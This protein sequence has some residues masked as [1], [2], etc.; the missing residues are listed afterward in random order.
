LIAAYVA[1]QPQGALASLAKG[2]WLVLA[3]CQILGKMAAA[4]EGRIMLLLDGALKVLILLLHA[5][6]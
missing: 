4:C 2:K 5:R 1:P 3:A 6:V